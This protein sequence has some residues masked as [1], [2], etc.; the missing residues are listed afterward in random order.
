MQELGTIDVSMKHYVGPCHVRVWEHGDPFPAL[1]RSVGVDTETELITDTKKDPPVVVTGV[2]DPANQTCWVIY[3]YDTAEFMRQLNLRNV[4]QRYFNLGFDEQVINNEDEQK[5][6]LEAI[7]S[8]R[9]RDMQARIHC[10]EIATVGFI[11]GNLH[12]LAGCTLHFLNHELDKGDPDDYENSAR[13]TFKRYNEDG[14]IYKITEEQAQYLPYDCISTWCLGEAVPEQPTEVA[15]TKGMVVLAHI[16]TNGQQVDPVVFG[17]LENKLKAA[18]DEARMRLLS[19]GFP[20]PYKDQKNDMAEQKELLYR[21]YSKFCAHFGKPAIIQKTI[22]EEDGSVSYEGLPNKKAVR[23]MLTYMYNF[24]DNPEEVLDFVVCVLEAMENPKMTFGKK[25]TAVYAELCESLELG[26]FDSASKAIVLISLMGHIFQH[27]NQQIETGYIWQY[28][29]N[30]TSAVTDASNFLDEHAD[31]LTA[32][33]TIGPRKFFQQHVQKVLDQN[34]DLELERT[35][36]SGDIKLTLKDRWRLEDLDIDDKFLDAYIDFNHCQKY[37]STYMN[38]EFIKSDN[39]VHPRFTN[40]LRTGRTS[41]S[42]P[43]VQNLPSRDKTYPLKN[44]YVPYDGMILCATDFSFIEL[45]AFAQSCY[46]R[47]GF[48]VMRD[49]INAGLDPH[50][51]FGGVMEKIITPDLTHKDDPVWV[52]ETKQFLKENVPDA[53]RQKAKAANFGFPGALGVRTFFKNCRESGVKLTMDDAKFMRDSWINTFKEMK[54]HMQ[55]EEIK[56]ARAYGN[57]FGFM[58]DDEDDVEIDESEKNRQMYRCVLPCGQVRNRC[59]YNA[60][61][62]TQFQ[63]TTA[64]G[65]KLAGWNLVL[66]GYGQRLYNFVHDE[67]LYCLYPDELKIHIPQIEKLMIA[68]MKTVI[69]DVK[70]GVESSCML[71]WD[72]KAATFEEIK[73]DEA[74][75]PII[76]EPAFVKDIYEQMNYGQKA[77]Y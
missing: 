5:T 73:W 22:N 20:D 42:A 47:F 53:L 74:G 71:H 34:P 24:M 63:G 59:S 8:G 39:R 70:V 54:L 37:L 35:E 36:K 56:S 66:H 21:E 40:I 9:V 32:T 15:H 10:H 30:F 17:F 77:A 31:W 46:S 29:F 69:P 76:E 62:N 58:E 48:S 16:S 23:L 75:N 3:W 2:F 33:E 52:K 1:G 41:C 6:L 68:G 38:R 60:A 64:V 27:L 4:Q 45:C 51:W 67:Y 50:R 57:A 43:N 55:P 44:V 11:R 25:Q 61:C 13:M 26:A 72:K 65:A 18:R 14:S 7:D 12:S 49:V 19:F 28:G